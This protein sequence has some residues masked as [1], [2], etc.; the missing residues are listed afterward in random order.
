MRLRAVTVS[1]FS[2][3]FLVPIMASPA[4]TM[5]MVMVTNSSVSVNPRQRVEFEWMVFFMGFRCSLRHHGRKSFL[6]WV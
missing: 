5:R 1:A 2:R 3:I 6:G 4:M